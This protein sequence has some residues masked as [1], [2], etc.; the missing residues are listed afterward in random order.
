MGNKATGIGQ[1]IILGPLSQAIG[2]SD[3]LRPAGARRPVV[4]DLVF[5]GDTG[6]PVE[7]GVDSR[8]WHTLLE[9]AGV[10]RARLHDARHTAATV[11]LELGWF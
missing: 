7:P 5:A 3:N 6:R 8:A 2:Q 9:A 1:A 4:V 10:P 11:M